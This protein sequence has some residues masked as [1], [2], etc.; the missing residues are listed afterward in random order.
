MVTYYRDATVEITSDRLRVGPAGYPISALHRVWHRRG[1]RRWSGV[2]N[3]GALG[4][5]MLGPLV[6]ATF[7]ILVALLLETS[8][9]VTA[10]I[11]AGSVVVGLAAVP[12]ADL[13]LDQVDRSYDRGTRELELWALIGGAPVRLLHST[14]ARRFN[15]IYRALQRAVESSGVRS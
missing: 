6:A 13:L 2:V 3:R 12:V 5:L 8:I 9:A 1:S 14:D 7:G 11:V 15:Q 10:A 4:L